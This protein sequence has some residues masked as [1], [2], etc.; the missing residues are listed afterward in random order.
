[1]Q[2]IA[3][4]IMLSFG[5]ILGV[6][7]ADNGTLIECMKSGHSKL[8]STQIQCQVPKAGGSISDKSTIDQNAIDQSVRRSYELLISRLVQKLSEQSGEES[9]VADIPKGFSNLRPRGKSEAKTESTNSDR[10]SADA[11]SDDAEDG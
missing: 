6:Y 5:L 9:D 10:K 3:S 11:I 8:N 7:I 4:V 2:I 1:M